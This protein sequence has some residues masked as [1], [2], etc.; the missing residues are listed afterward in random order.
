MPVVC[1]GQYLRIWRSSHSP[2]LQQCRRCRKRAQQRL[3]PHVHAHL[4]HREE[5]AHAD[6]TPASTCDES[7]VPSPSC[8]Y[9]RGTGRDG[10]SRAVC[11][12]KPA[13]QVPH[14]RSLPPGAGRNAARHCSERGQALLPRLANGDC[15]LQREH[16]GLGGQLPEN[17]ARAAVGQGLA[18]MELR[19]R[20]DAREDGAKRGQGLA[21]DPTCI[22]GVAQQV[23]A[24]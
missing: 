17:A 5:R 7:G 23:K 4:F 6:K 3:H 8:G 14:Q 16:D 21:H 11:S 19:C 2:Q 24:G 15:E 12:A 22:Q 9:G 18:M 10:A 1:R 20:E 13:L